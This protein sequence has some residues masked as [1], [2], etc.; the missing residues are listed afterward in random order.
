MSLRIWSGKHTL[1]ELS[2][3]RT[4]QVPFIYLIIRWRVEYYNVQ[5]I[6]HVWIVQM[7]LLESVRLASLLTVLIIT[8][9]AKINLR[10]RL[11]ITLYEDPPF[12]VLTESSTIVDLCRHRLFATWLQ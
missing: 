12:P 6:I 3:G 9:G 10:Q 11:A 8:G 7:Y 4:S 5:L 2:A 1:K